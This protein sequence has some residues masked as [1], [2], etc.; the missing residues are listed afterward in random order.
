MSW[1]S[2]SLLVQVLQMSTGERRCLHMLISPLIPW[3][4]NQLF[5]SRIQGQR[6]GISGQCNTENQTAV[7]CSPHQ[8][9]TMNLGE[10]CI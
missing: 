3:W 5:A 7:L 1:S 9:T 6:D 10:L 4:G 8:I 2:K